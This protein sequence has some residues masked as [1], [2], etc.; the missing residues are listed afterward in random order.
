MQ[1]AAKLSWQQHPSH[2]RVLD[3]E[4]SLGTAS[5]LLRGVP[6]TSLIQTAGQGEGKEKT[7]VVF[8]ATTCPGEK[9]DH[10]L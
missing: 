5:L 3:L 1:V 4:S 8:A 6:N 9:W 10:P 2:P 7:Q